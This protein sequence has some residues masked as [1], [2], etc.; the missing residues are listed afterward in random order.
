M[1]ARLSR[2]HC[3]FFLFRLTG[4]AS[5]R[6]DGYHVRVTMK[7]KKPSRRDILSCSSEIGPDDGV[8]P[9]TFFRKPS[10]WKTNR[11]ALQ[12]CGQIARTLSRVLA[13]ESADELLRSLTVESVE[14]APDSTRVL[15]TVSSSASA[16]TQDAAQLLER[17][18]RATGKLRTEVAAS[19]HRKRVPEL[20][21]RVLGREV[22]I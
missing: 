1:A 4:A 21:F 3:V 15:V 20:I 2:C 13:W 9:R 8:D 11:K 12:L 17:L 22:T 5:V 10:N 7:S 18:R 6:A 16:A 19:I 14:P